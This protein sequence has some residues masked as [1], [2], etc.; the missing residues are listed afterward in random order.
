[1][2]TKTKK[3]KKKRQDTNNLCQK[4]DIIPIGHANNSL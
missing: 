1:M 2:L 3:Q 4:G